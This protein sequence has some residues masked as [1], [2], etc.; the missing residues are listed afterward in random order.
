M[1]AEG[2][3]SCRRCLSGKAFPR[4]G[5]SPKAGHPLVPLFEGKTGRSLEIRVLL[6]LK[7][8]ENTATKH[9][10]VKGANPALYSPRRHCAPR[11][12]PRCDVLNAANEKRLDFHRTADLQRAGVSQILFHTL[13]FLTPSSL[14]CLHF[15]AD[16]TVL[17]DSSPYQLL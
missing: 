4:K 12:Q 3:S 16:D 1:D 15:A 17:P 8:F 6:N 14:C 11:S 7:E 10:R 5:E 13:F 9:K 2:G